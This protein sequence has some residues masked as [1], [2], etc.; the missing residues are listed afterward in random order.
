MSNPY[1]IIGYSMSNLDY[2]LLDSIE[3]TFNNLTIKITKSV[4]MLFDKFY[5]KILFDCDKNKIIKIKFVSIFN[6]IKHPTEYYL[7]ANF[8]NNHICEN[9]KVFQLQ[10]IYDMNADNSLLVYNR[11]SLNIFTNGYYEYV[12]YLDKLP[13]ITETNNKIGTISIG[14]IQTVLTHIKEILIFFTNIET[15][16]KE[17]IVN[18]FKITISDI[19]NEYSSLDMEIYSKLHHTTNTID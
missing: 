19:S 3:I 18:K 8:I 11:E 6:K 13:Y 12:E 7:K 16:Q 14:N 17:K 2:E 9:N 10:N 15:N 5:E 4:I 1:G